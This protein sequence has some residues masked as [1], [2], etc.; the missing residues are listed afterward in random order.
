MN[1]LILR[2]Y[3]WQLKWRRVLGA[4]TR[5]NISNQI[6]SINFCSLWLTD[7]R[8]KTILSS[9]IRSRWSKWAVEASSCFHRHWSNQSARRRSGNQHHIIYALPLEWNCRRDPC[10]HRARLTWQSLAAWYLLF[11]NLH[12]HDHSKGC[13][14]ACPCLVWYFRFLACK[15]LS[16]PTK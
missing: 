7:C 15:S 2:H 8:P 12:I 3:S 5:R 16:T 4:P 9:E 14:Q 6:Y 11:P 13:F 10:H 1:Q